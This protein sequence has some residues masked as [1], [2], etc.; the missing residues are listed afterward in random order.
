MVKRLRAEEDAHFAALLE[1]REREF[2]TEEEHLRRRERAQGGGDFWTAVENPCWS[3]TLPGRG[4]RH[5]ATASGLGR[6]GGILAATASDQD[7]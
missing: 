2:E 1:E 3:S 6:V 7:L 5:R 4:W